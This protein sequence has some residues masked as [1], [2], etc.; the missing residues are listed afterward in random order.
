MIGK[1]PHHCCIYSRES[2]NKIKTVKLVQAPP[3][4]FTVSA[5]MM[6]PMNCQL[7]LMNIFWYSLSML[8]P[9]HQHH[10]HQSIASTRNSSSQCHG[11][12]LEGWGG[13]SGMICLP[14]LFQ[15]QLQLIDNERHSRISPII[16]H[17]H[18]QSMPSRLK[19]RRKQ[20]GGGGGEG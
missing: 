8:Q 15:D 20:G 1:C 3:V 7:M 14:I 16:L 9:R 19:I 5:Y 4:P 18:S 17:L 2:Q 12:M 13:W 6:F 11:D 10:W